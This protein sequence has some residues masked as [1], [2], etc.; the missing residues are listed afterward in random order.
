MFSAQFWAEFLVS[1]FFWLLPMTIGVLSFIWLLIW[2]NRSIGIHWRKDVWEIIKNDPQA[3]A[4]Y[5]GDR[6]IAV[7]IAVAGLS[8]AGAI[9]GNLG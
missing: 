5:F 1:R 9:A 7:A 4:D 6:V 2:M 3:L 8:I